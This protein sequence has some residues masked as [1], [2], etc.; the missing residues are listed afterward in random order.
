MHTGRGGAEARTAQGTYEI[1]Q[2]AQKDD[3]GNPILNKRGKPV[4]GQIPGVPKGARGAGA[5]A[6]EFRHTQ[7]KEEGGT[8]LGAWTGR[9]P[10]GKPGG[11]LS[12]MRKS[13]NQ[14][15]Q[16]NLAALDV[17]RAREGLPTRFQ[18]ELDP[19]KPYNIL[20]MPRR[21]PRR[22]ISDRPPTPTTPTT[23]ASRPDLYLNLR[24]TMDDISGEDPEGS[25]PEELT[26]AWPGHK[27]PL[28][29]ASPPPRKRNESDDDYA[30]R[31]KP[32]KKK[33][34]PSSPWSWMTD[35]S[36]LFKGKS[37]REML[38]RRIKEVSKTK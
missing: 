27:K 15:T 34:K 1:P 13:W 5:R 33:K 6:P 22:T 38:N 8:G 20:G 7:S 24:K 16:Q 25:T 12:R 17:Q 10:I 23:P 9:K 29:P 30:A 26:K 19:E 3:E 4:M 37:L 14:M 21:A 2:V 28:D 31:I 36:I 35:S 18:R 32:K 11:M